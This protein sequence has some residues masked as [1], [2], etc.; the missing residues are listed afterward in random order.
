MISLTRQK[1]LTSMLLPKSYLI[2]EERWLRHQ[3]EEDY[4]LESI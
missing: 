4:H 2:L 1:K 3:A